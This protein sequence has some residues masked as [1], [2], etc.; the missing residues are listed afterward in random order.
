MKYLIIEL[1]I[2]YNKFWMMFQINLKSKFNKNST[3]K[4]KNG[5]LTVNNNFLIKYNN[6]IKFCHMRK[7]K[8][9]LN[10]KIKPNNLSKKKI[11]KMNYNNISIIQQNNLK[12]QLKIK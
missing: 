1:K 7:S 12:N 5:K 4:Y 8:I 11:Q 3:E 2:F 9:L 6:S 10:F